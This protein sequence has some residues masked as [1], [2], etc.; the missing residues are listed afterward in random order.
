MNC[1]HSRRMMSS[2]MEG[3]FQ[4]CG[5]ARDAKPC[6]TRNRLLP[7]KKRHKREKQK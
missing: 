2:P 3:L 4:P 5:D 1:W 6:L 7:L